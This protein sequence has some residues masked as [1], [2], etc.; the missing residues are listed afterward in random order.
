[1]V[2]KEHTKRYSSVGLYD[3]DWDRIDRNREARETKVG[4]IEEAIQL[5]FD[6]REGRAKVSRF[7]SLT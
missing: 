1:M 3:E 2:K 5:L 7:T 6:V 4:F